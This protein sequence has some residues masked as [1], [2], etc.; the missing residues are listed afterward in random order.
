MDAFIEETLLWTKADGSPGILEDGVHARAP[1][2]ARRRVVKALEIYPET[3]VG[4]D[5]EDFA[6]DR[7]W[8]DERHDGRHRLATTARLKI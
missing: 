2:E 4:D 6:D 1:R 8:I 7:A 3:F 5:R